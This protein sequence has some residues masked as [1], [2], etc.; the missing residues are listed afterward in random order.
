MDNVVEVS[1]KLKGRIMLPVT[2]KVSFMSE[3]AILYVI[4][5]MATS[6]MNIYNNK[7]IIAI[8][9]KKNLF[10]LANVIAYV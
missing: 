7:A 2:F 8:T 3:L 6:N 9:F 10:N 5:N 1:I 4:Y